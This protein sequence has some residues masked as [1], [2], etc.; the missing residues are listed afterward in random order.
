MLLVK[1][2]ELIEVVEIGPGSLR[3]V[4]FLSHQA[5]FGSRGAEKCSTC[6]LQLNSA[7]DGVF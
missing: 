3:G 1:F 5:K 6:L 2:R 7:L 4:S